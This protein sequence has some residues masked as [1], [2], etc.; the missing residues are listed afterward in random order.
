MLPSASVKLTDERIFIT[1]K[2]QIVEW[3]EEINYMK[4]LLFKKGRDLIN[5]EKII[6]QG[7]YKAKKN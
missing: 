4:P 5:V 1:I 7:K 6:N 2:E 3:D